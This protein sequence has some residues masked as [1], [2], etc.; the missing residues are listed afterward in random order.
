M[1]KYI[2]CNR[3][4]NSFIYFALKKNMVND[5]NNSTGKT[6]LRFQNII[7]KVGNSDS[8][9]DRH[10]FHTLPTAA[11]AVLNAE[12]MSQFFFVNITI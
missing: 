5:N 6:S 9:S 3:C 12:N 4:I 10:F 7:I 11:S 8:H 2:I 1:T